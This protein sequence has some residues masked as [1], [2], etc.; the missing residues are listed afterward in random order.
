MISDHDSTTVDQ[1]LDVLERQIGAGAAGRRRWRR[2]AV[3]LAVCTV[4][5][6]LAGGAAIRHHLVEARAF[7][8]RDDQGNM[9]GSFVLSDDGGVR[10]T[11]FDESRTARAGVWLEPTGRASLWGFD[12]MPSAGASAW[13]S[14][15][16]STTVT[17]ARSPWMQTASMSNRPVRHQ[18]QGSMTG[19]PTMGSTTMGSTET[20]TVKYAAPTTP[21][22]QWSSTPTG[23]LIMLSSSARVIEKYH[24]S[25]TCGYQVTVRNDSVRPIEQAY[26]VTFIDEGGF[27]LAR[28]ARMLRLAP[29]QQTALHGE[30][31]L[32]PARA[33][34][35]AHVR[36]TAWTP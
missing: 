32:T 27:V 28:Q 9:R 29:Y 13:P 17:P 35:I 30:I 34:Q 23:A 4:T 20:G 18:Q 10:L 36:L 7:I 25:W 14:E 19:M 21:W 6:V 11:L 5:G 33:N 26:Y 3:V 8:L 12:D 24:E 31:D 15:Q 2:L 1:R 22:Q 16:V